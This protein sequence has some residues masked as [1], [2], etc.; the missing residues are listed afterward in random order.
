MPWSNDGWRPMTPSPNRRNFYGLPVFLWLKP[1]DG[2]HRTDAQ[3]DPGGQGPM[4]EPETDP[5]NE[6]YTSAIL[7][8]H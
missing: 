2:H 1:G 4:V 5:R 8:F 6:N 3:T 7:T